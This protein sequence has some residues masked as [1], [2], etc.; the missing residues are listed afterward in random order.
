MQYREF[1]FGLVVCLWLVFGLGYSQAQTIGNQRDGHIPPSG[2]G[3]TTVG[4]R[5]ILFDDRS[6]KADDFYHRESVL[7]ITDGGRTVALTQTVDPKSEQQILS[8]EYTGSHEDKIQ[9][10]VSRALTVVH[11]K[12]TGQTNCVPIITARNLSGQS[13]FRI[14]AELQFVSAGKEVS[15]TSVMIGPL[16]SGEGRN[17]TSSPLYDVACKNVTANLHVPFCKLSNGLDCRK[18]VIASKFSAIALA[19]VEPVVS[20]S[21]G[22]STRKLNPVGGLGQQKERNSDSTPDTRTPRNRSDREK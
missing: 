3:A 4:Q 11:T 2:I 22:I 6:W 7:A 17:K 14:V 16:D 9:V 21:G 10:L 19:A 18:L 20:T 5:I 13:L 1:L 15:A 12:D 8:W